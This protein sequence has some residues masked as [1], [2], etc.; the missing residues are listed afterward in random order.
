MTTSTTGSRC[1]TVGTIASGSRSYAR[2]ARTLSAG[3]G[4]LSAPA[5]IH[6]PPVTR[7]ATRP[8]QSFTPPTLGGE[9]E[10]T[11]ESVARWAK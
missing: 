2:T 10:S 1:P 4:S 7:R 9:A 8:N 11:P 5:T 3:W 6:T